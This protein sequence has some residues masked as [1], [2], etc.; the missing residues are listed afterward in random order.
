M[1]MKPNILF[2]HV[3]QMHADAISALGCEHVHT[4][5]IDELVREGYTFTN[6]YCAMPQCCPS[7]ACW[8]TGR[9]SKE[10]GGVVNSYPIDSSIPDLGQWLRRENYDCVYTG[11]WHVTGRDLHASF[12]VLQPQHGMGELNDGNVARSAVAY[13]KNRTSDKPFFLSVGFLIRHDDLLMWP[14][15]PTAAR[16]NT[17][18]HRKLRAISRLFRAI[19]TTNT[20]SAD[21]PVL[22]SGRA[23]IGS[24]IFINITAWSKW[25]MPKSGA[26]CTP[27]A[28]RLTLTTPSS[29]SPLTT[30]MASAFTA[31]PARA[32]SKKKLFAFLPLRGGPGV[33]PKVCGMPSTSSL[34]SIFPLRYATMLAH[35]PCPRPLLR[36]H[37]V[38]FLNGAMPRAHAYV[39]G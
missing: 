33:F 27:F 15:G 18:L 38:P 6:A 28:H 4:P 9:M 37:G 20:L 31:I 12:D 5:A 32:F 17:L 8:Y 21:G 1:L 16:A 36:V 3:D 26:L 2:I 19:S 7:R 23:A 34:A 14:L 11:K 35:R 24:I 39:I 10:H 30:A 29:S 25:S 13:L 22:A